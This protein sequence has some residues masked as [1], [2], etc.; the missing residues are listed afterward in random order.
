MKNSEEND[1]PIDEDWNAKGFLTSLEYLSELSTKGGNDIYV[2]EGLL[3]VTKSYLDYSIISK[4]RDLHDSI[5]RKYIDLCDYAQN[6]ALKSK[7]DT[8]EKAMVTGQFVEAL[9]E[10]GMPRIAAIQATAVWLDIGESTVRTSNENF[11]KC[12]AYREDKGLMLI[13]YISSMYEKIKENESFDFT[14]PKAKAAF[15]RT[16]KYY[17]ERIEHRENFFLSIDEATQK[18]SA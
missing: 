14:H 13:H 8:H 6:H 7:L 16:K 9:I 4:D 15:F 17:E 1:E 11:R 18:D 12:F 3:S 10:H 2:I 5:M